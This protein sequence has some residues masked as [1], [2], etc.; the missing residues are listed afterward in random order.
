MSDVMSEY[1]YRGRSEIPSET[2]SA[3][4]SY[5][6]SRRSS[7]SLASRTSSGSSLARRLADYANVRNIP[8]PTARVAGFSNMESNA[9][10]QAYRLNQ[11]E[12]ERRR[13]IQTLK[14]QIQ[15]GR[16]PPAPLEDIPSRPRIYNSLETRADKIANQLY[17]FP[18]TD[19]AVYTRKINTP[20]VFS[21]EPVFGF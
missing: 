13:Y 11:L 5:P 4:G 8:R 17:L 19:P 10:E 18:D 3:G 20:N 14:K 12:Y 1:R 16:G 21:H 2:T 7:M 15:H 6:T 9:A